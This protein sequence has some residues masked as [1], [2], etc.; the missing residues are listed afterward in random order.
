MGMPPSTTQATGHPEAQAED[1]TV[2]VQH[3]QLAAAPHRRDLPPGQGGDDLVRAE[4][5]LQE[6]GI[7]RRHL[8][9]GASHHDLGRLPVALH[10]EDLRHEGEHAR[11]VVGALLAAADRLPRRLRAPP[12]AVAAHRAALGQQG[13]PA[14]H[15]SRRGAVPRAGRG[16]PVVRGQGGHQRRRRPDGRGQAEAPAAARPPQPH[17]GLPRGRAG[18]LRSQGARRLPAHGRAAD[19]AAPAEAIASRRHAR[20]AGRR[21]RP[22]R[23]AHPDGT[24]DATTAVRPTSERAE[25][26]PIRSGSARARSRPAGRRGARGRPRRG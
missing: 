17:P 12:L 24:R 4:A 2:G 25:L 19:G 20:R 13:R 18:G 5:P 22:G 6:P 11:L 8:G 14:V 3:E 9:D 21:G 1:R 26:G 23:A 16:R 7:G 15:L 10:L